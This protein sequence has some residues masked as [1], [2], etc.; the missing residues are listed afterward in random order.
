MY[1]KRK[2]CL[3]VSFP[4]T[5]QLLSSAIFVLVATKPVLTRYTAGGYKNNI[6]NYDSA[7]NSKYNSELEL[8]NTSNLSNFVTQVFFI[9]V[10]PPTALP[11]VCLQFN[12]ITPLIYFYFVFFLL[13]LY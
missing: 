13:F 11:Y 8:L 12:E 7:N 9:C 4:A 2:K 10:A 6:Y 3:L 5:L 1:G